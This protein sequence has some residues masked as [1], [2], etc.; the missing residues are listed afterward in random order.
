MQNDC[1]ERIGCESVIHLATQDI[2]DQPIKRRGATKLIELSASSE[3][4]LCDFGVRRVMVVA[5]GH[6]GCCLFRV[7]SR[8]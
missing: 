2:N 7:V 8:C 3:V 1:H 4:R 6:G 5:G